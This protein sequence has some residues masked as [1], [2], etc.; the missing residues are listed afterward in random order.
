MEENTLM[1]ARIDELR[2]I[3]N[4]LMNINHLVSNEDMAFTLSKELSTLFPYLNGCV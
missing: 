2:T 1:Q 3:A 4:Q